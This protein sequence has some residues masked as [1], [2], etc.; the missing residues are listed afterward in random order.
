MYAWFAHSKKNIFQFKF[1]IFVCKTLFPISQLLSWCMRNNYLGSWSKKDL[2]SSGSCQRMVLS[3]P[4]SVHRQSRD[5]THSHQHYRSCSTRLRNVLWIFLPRP[6]IEP[7]SFSMSGDAY[8]NLATPLTN[9]NSLAYLK[10]DLKGRII[11]KLEIFSSYKLEGLFYLILK[12]W[13]FFPL[14]KSY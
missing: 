11:D 13:S 10:W 6:R 12:V 4:T 1:F 2:S 8:T 3:S 5:L 9:W 7:G 14:F